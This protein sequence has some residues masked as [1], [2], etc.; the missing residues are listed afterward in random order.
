MYKIKKKLMTNCDKVREFNRAFG[1][2]TPA[3]PQPG[4]FV[5]DPKLVRLKMDLIK[6][7]VREL[8]EAVA[9][10]D[11]KE[12]ADALA[13]ILYVVYGMGI[14]FGLDMDGAF[15]IVHRSNMSKLCR[16]EEEA[17]ET[18]A[19]YRCEYQKKV[20]PYDSPAYRRA[21]GSD[22]YIVY[23]EST[24]KILKN[25]HYHPADLLPVISP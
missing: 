5:S 13:D 23:N 7:E 11:L 10:H 2:D 22:L 4:L 15:D 20:L 8:E 17:L 21:D 9:N 19:W 6:E 3:T 1:I 16:T 14:A 12:T 25:I 24:G 18:V